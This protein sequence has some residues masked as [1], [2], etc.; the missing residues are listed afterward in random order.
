MDATLFSDVSERLLVD[1]VCREILLT[2]TQEILREIVTEGL[3]LGCHTVITEDVDVAGD[4]RSG[5]MDTK[6]MEDA[7]PNPNWSGI[8]D[9]NGTEE[10]QRNRSGIADIPEDLDEYPDDIE[11]T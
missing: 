5:M 1:D 2:I 6:G 10:P 11:E 9:T 4:N 7:N 8:S 3:S